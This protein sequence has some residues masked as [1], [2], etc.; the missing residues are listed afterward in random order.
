[1][2]GCP[3]KSHGRCPMCAA[4][5]RAVLLLGLAAAGPG[6]CAQSLYGVE[7]ADNDEDGYFEG[8]DCNDDDASVYPGAPDP[9]GDGIDQD[10]DGEDGSSDSGM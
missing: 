2:P 9:E 7:L 4:T 3:H 5:A 6:A 1:M 8:E 10:C